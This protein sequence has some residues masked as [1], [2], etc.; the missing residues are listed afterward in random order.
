MLIAFVGVT[1]WLSR[2]VSAQTE[3]PRPSPEVNPQSRGPSQS[4]PAP[5][6]AVHTDPCRS[7]KLFPRLE[8]S[9]VLGLDG[10]LAGDRVRDASSHHT[11]DIH[12]D[13]EP[14]LG[15]QYPVVSGFPQRPAG[16]QPFTELPIDNQAPTRRRPLGPRPLPVLPELKQANQQRRPPIGTQTFRPLFQTEA[17]NSHDPRKKTGCGTATLDFASDCSAPASCSSSYPGVCLD[18]ADVSQSETTRTIP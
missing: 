4:N 10:M 5:L 11:F 9:R 6:R 14:F 7:T 13:A 1:A 2:S 12:S 8:P 3:S 18:L 15:Q 16:A 17:S